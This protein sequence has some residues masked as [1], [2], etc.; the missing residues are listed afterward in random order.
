MV[1]ISVLLLSLIE[2]FFVLPAHLAHVGRPGRLMGA[3]IRYQSVVSRG[4]ER[5]IE[6][7]YAPVARAALRQ[8]WLTLAIGICVALA[9]VGLLMGGQVKR[10]G[11]P[12]EESD[13]VVVNAGLQYGVSIEETRAVMDRLVT[14]ANQVIEENGGQRI[15]RGILSVLG[16]ARTNR[17]RQQQGTHLTQVV[18]TLVPT[19]Q[20]L[21][22]RC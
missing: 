18:V 20:R 22:C 5:F 11:F 8:R 6:R 19:D 15:N 14:A 7:I 1:A 10:V 13:W 21:L 16:S 4:V 3:I 2:S 17:S 9:S 12:K